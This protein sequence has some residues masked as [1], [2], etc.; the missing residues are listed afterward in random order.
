MT[1]NKTCAASKE[2]VPFEVEGG[3]VHWRGLLEVSVL[4]RVSFFDGSAELP[5]TRE[6]GIEDINGVGVLNY[7]VNAPG[8]IKI[9]GL[10]A[11]G[12]LNY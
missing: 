1:Y 4:N 6:G 8:V 3:K 5:H 7:E 2:V 11:G 12:K 9:L 10:G